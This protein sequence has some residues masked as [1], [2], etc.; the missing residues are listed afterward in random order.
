[1]KEAQLFIE[2]LTQENLW[3]KEFDVA[4]NDFV[5]VGGTIDTQLYFIE[6]GS[7]RI[8]VLEED[9]EQTIRFG[10]QQNIIVSMDSFINE[11]P[12]DFYIQAIKKTRLKVISK[13]RF[14]DWINTASSL[15]NGW[16]RILEQ[17]L[18]QQLERERDLLTSSPVERYHRVLKRSPQLF[19]EIPNKYIANYLRMTPETLS[20]IKKS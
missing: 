9:E 18:L 10:Y 20:R 2:R 19:Q 15:Q 12:S 3:E 16:Q 5:K 11:M 7:L 17:L 4:R 6:K 14:T 1:M 8:Y 13:K